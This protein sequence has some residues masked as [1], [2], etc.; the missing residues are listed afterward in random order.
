[1]FDWTK[2][3]LLSGEYE[4]ALARLGVMAA[5]AEAEG[6]I[7]PW[8]RNFQGYFHELLGNTEASRGFY[9]KA[10]DEAR[11]TLDE[12]P[13]LAPNHNALAVAAAGLGQKELALR[14]N[15]DAYQLVEK[16][17]FW[18]PSFLEGRAAIYAMLDEPDSAIDLLDEL[19]AMPY[20]YPITV[21]LLRLEPRWSPL[22]DH[23]RFQA[24]LD[25]YETE[26]DS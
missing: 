16:D 19:L 1:L 11:Q 7:V 26:I 9:E 6:E 24:L 15:Q 4:T 21:P 20:D 3:S 8:V 13:Q 5:A 22:H 18:A 14:K 25:K 17:R 23:P 10:I 12:A 2:I